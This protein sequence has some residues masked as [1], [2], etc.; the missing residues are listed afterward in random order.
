MERLL[1]KTK[2]HPSEVFATNNKTIHFGYEWSSGPAIST[3]F[4]TLVYKGDRRPECSENDPSPHEWCK[5]EIPGFNYHNSVSCIAKYNLCEVFVS[6][7]KK[8]NW[9]KDKSYHLRPSLEE[10]W[11][12]IMWSF[13]ALISSTFQMSHEKNS[14]FPLNPDCFTGILIIKGLL[15][16][17]YNCVVYNL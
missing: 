7:L 2:K 15:Q 16:S 1:P 12:I 14:F 3:T 6:H 11:L 5:T 9:T 4:V 13:S 8:F 17:P 10:N